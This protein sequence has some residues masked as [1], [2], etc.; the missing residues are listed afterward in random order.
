[1]LFLQ[2]TLYLHSQETHSSTPLTGE[3]KSLLTMATSF[4][5]TSVF[6]ALIILA[7]ARPQVQQQ[8][9]AFSI[10]A[11]DDWVSSGNYRIYS[12]ASEAQDVK[13][14]L[15]FTYLSLQTAI[16]ATGGSAYRAFFRSAD[17]GSVTAV[18]K[19]ITEGKNVTTARYGSRRPIMAC[20]NAL[21]PNIRAFWKL[22]HDS[23]DTVVIQPPETAIV[24]LCPLFFSRKPLPLP[25][26]CGVVNHA[27]TRLIP[28][29]HI[30]DSQ[31]GFLV[32]A[33][34]DIYIRQTLPGTVAQGGGVSDENAC[35]ALPPDLALKNSASY[36]YYASSK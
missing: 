11:V 10:G 17:P 3:F 34:A 2:R 20:V 35:L 27:S 21:D 31:Y 28:R 25:A 9:G 1:M 36:A 8:A 16:R 22:C 23:E 24:F 29:S 19:A 12:C 33:L 6:L 5:K 13:N 18:L 32:Q 7:S 15:D 26:D 14:A 30:N 4:L